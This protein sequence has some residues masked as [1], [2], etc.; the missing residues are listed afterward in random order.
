MSAVTAR[1]NYA[2][3]CAHLDSTWRPT[4]PALPAPAA[5]V[6]GVLRLR[7]PGYSQASL[8]F[9]RLG[10]GLGYSQRSQHSNDAKQH[11]HWDTSAKKS[12]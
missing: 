2:L 9:D 12:Q 1:P 10:P 6:A 7:R 11:F 5:L 3:L 8:S 4:H